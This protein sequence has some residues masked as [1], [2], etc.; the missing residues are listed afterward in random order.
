MR[1]LSLFHPTVAIK[2]LRSDGLGL[3]S[4]QETLVSDSGANTLSP[5]VGSIPDLERPRGILTVYFRVE[6]AEKVVVEECL[7]Q[8]HLGEKRS[9]AGDHAAILCPNK[10][11]VYLSPCGNNGGV[12]YESLL[13]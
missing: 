8:V 9:G 10:E 1:L 6:A 11:G 7:E 12:D 5:E 4:S 2:A 3:L 13:F